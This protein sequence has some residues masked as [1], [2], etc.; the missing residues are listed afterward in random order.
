MSDVPASCTIVFASV[1]IVLKVIMDISKLKVK[2][3]YAYR[4]MGKIL[5]D[6]IG[7]CIQ[8]HSVWQE[9]KISIFCLCLNFKDK[10]IYMY[11]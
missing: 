6:H 7:V 3:E 2:V 10:N 4:K 9:N 1:L 8:N 5:S 11:K